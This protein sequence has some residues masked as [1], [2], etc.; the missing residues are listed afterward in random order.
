MK[1]ILLGIL[2]IISG[3][4]LGIIMHSLIGFVIDFLCGAIGGFLIMIVI[5]KKILKYD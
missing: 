3:F 4:A 1:L 5:M 2:F